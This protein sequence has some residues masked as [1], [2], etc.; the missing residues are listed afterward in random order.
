MSRRRA[1]TDASAARRRLSTAL[2][3][4]GLAVLPACTVTPLYSTA[5]NGNA[6]QAELAAISIL[7]ATDRLTQIARNELVF[8]FGSGQGVPARYEL[9][10]QAASGSGP[11]VPGANIPLTRLTV[12]IRYSLVELE[13]G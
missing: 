6:V 1:L 2:V 9:S 13:V 10:L 5:D 12:T 3:L 8:A 7:P 11:D 4:L